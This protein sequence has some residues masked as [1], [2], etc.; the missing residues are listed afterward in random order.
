MIYKAYFVS[1]M[2]RPLLL[3]FFFCSLSAFGQQK[4]P[5]FKLKFDKVVMYDYLPDGEKAGTVISSKGELVSTVIRKVQL[6]SITVQRLNQ[7]LGEKKSYGSGTAFCFNP[8]LGIVYYG[9]DKI[10]AHISVCFAC[11]RLRSSVEIPAQKQG[12]V[13]EGKDAYYI[14]DGLSKSFR[15]FLNALVK[16][17][18]FSHQIEPG[19]GF[20]E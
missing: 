19:S 11:N 3:A 20:D 15:F 16:K 7:K 12:R 9:G 10:V 18:G 8:H 4:N 6:D 14:S 5:F 17:H 2:K 1:F 13:G